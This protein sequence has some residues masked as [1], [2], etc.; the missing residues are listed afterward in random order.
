MRT[1]AACCIGT[2]AFSG[3]S[4]LKPARRK[5]HRPRSDTSHRRVRLLLGRCEAGAAHRVGRT[6]STSTPLLTNSPTGRRACGVVAAKIQGSLRTIVAEVTGDRR[7]PG[8]T[9]CRAVYVEGAEAGDVLEEEFFRST[10]RSTTATNGLRRFLSRNCDRAVAS[11]II[12][13]D[14]KTM[15]AEYMPAS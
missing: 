14:K 2:I 6:S 13:I 7:G 15:T 5:T 9:S 3:G 8:G 4:Q 12:P 10:F 1:S 11:R